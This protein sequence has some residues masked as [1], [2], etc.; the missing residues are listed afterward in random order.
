MVT[1]VIII[2]TFNRA[3]KLNILLNQLLK[4]HFTSLDVNL[5]FIVVIDGSSDGTLEMLVNKFPEV[6]LLK[7][8]G[9]WWYTKSMNEGFK[10]SQK[11]KPDFILT[12]N[13]D[14]EVNSEFIS[15]LLKDYKSLKIKDAVL[16]SISISNNKDAPYILFAGVKRH[17]RVGCKSEY[18]IEPLKEIYS[19]EIKGLHKTT[20][21]PGRGILIPNNVLKD[22]EYFDEGFPQY[23]SDTDFC[24]RAR[25]K[26]I[27]VYISWNAIVKVNL[28]TTR[29][30]SQSGINS[31]KQKVSDMFD[32]HSHQNLYKFIKFQK[33]HYSKIHLIWKIPY[34]IIS[35]LR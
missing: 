7:G 8:N 11:F 19:K 29:I 3:K 30:R 10:Y 26:G 27:P 16:G 15:I 22:L 28:K 14:I 9:N 24:F 2:P 20:E 5:K 4:Q 35:S 32:K 34:F 17:L 23:G 6:E 18:Y 25:K 21:L 33:R 12:M 13:D 1:I 31:F